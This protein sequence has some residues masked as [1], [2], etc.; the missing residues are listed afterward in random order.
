MNIEILR[1][2]CC[3][4]GDCVEIAPAVFMLDSK[5]HCVVLDADAAPRELLMEAAE[6]CPCAA[7]VVTDDAGEEVESGHATAE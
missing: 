2:R 7:I 6:A 3:G 4:N 1:A 5:Q